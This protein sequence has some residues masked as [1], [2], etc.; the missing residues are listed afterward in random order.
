MKRPIFFLLQLLDFRMSDEND[1]D[2]NLLE[3]LPE[4]PFR[5]ILRMLEKEDKNN[6]RLVSKR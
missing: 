6:L 4:V 1:A 3:A 5:N 2:W